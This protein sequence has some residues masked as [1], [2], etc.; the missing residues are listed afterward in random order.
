MTGTQNEINSPLH[1]TLYAIHA[2]TKFSPFELMFGWIPKLPIDLVYDQTNSDELRAKIE[3]KWI[4]L[5]F[6]DQQ[7]KEMKAMIDF[8]AANRDA[9]SLRGSTL[10]DRTV[11]GANLKVGDKI[12]VLDQRKKVG[13]N[14]KL[15][16]RWKGPD[17]VTDMFN[18]VNAILKADDR[19]RKTKIVHLCKLKRYSGKQPVVVINSQE[20]SVNESNMI[21]NSFDPAS[22][23][24]NQKGERGRIACTNANA[25]DSR[26][27]ETVYQPLDQVTVQDSQDS[28]NTVIRLLSKERRRNKE[29]FQSNGISRAART[30]AKIT[31]FDQSDIEGETNEYN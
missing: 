5:D 24:P 12:W 29:N 7:R 19:S 9:A 30:S 1:T 15:R 17:L 27:E 8:A 3:V 6:M 25:N 14:P 20:H 2:V 23:A 31:R 4:A 28:G 10:N 18:E 13:S 21:S 26:D 11:R 16:R 22:P